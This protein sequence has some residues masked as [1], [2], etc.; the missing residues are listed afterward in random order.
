MEIYRF[1]YIIALIVR[2]IVLR[3]ENIDGSLLTFCFWVFAEGFGPCLGALVA[4]VIFKRKFYCSITGKSV[5]K[6][7]LTMAL[8]LV[9]CFFLNRSLSLSMLGFILYSL[10]EEVGWRGYCK[11][12]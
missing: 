8:P 5:V 9:I 12:N 6:S 3:N 7:I 4:V 2:A 1:F 11:E 10:L